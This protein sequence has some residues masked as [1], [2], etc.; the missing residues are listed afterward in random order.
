[1]VGGAGDRDLGAGPAD[2]VAGARRLLGPAG[3]EQV[4]RLHGAREAADQRRAG[5]L[6]GSQQQHLTGVHG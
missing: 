1:M 5:L 4:L 2:D 3:A 6:V